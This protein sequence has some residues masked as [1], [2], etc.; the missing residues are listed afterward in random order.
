MNPPCYTPAKKN[1][2]LKKICLIF[3]QLHETLKNLVH[4]F[5]SFKKTLSIVKA[6]YYLSRK[7]G[8]KDFEF[9]YPL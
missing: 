4:G 8:S 6:R 2:S 7:W 3:H 9:V 1:F 5:Y